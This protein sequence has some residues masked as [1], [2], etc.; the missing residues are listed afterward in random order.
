MNEETPVQGKKSTGN[1]Y[2]IKNLCPFIADKEILESPTL[3]LSDSVI[4]AASVLLAQQAKEFDGWQIPQCGKH[5]QYKPVNPRQRFIQILHDNGHWIT[6]S[7]IDIHEGGVTD[8]I[9][10]FDSFQTSDVSLNTKK[11]VCAMIKS[12]SH[13]VKFDII[14]IMPQPNCCDRGAFVIVCVTE[15]VYGF[16]PSLCCW[17]VALMRRH[18]LSCFESGKM[19]RFPI[20]KTRR[21]PFG[22]RVKYM[23]SEKVYCVCRMPNERLRPMIQC[24][25]CFEWFHFDCIDYDS[26]LDWKCTNCVLFLRNTISEN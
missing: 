20:T 4:Y 21:V 7:N 19:I 22:R 25:N 14:N 10:V 9:N 12:N 2:W 24:E 5:F 3:W 11:Q 16:D 13:E 26:S 15:L 8:S 17:N 6:V 23:V 18:L 1:Q